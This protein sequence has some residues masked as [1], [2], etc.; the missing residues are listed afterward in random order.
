[1]YRRKPITFKHVMAR[2]A[3]VRTVKVGQVRVDKSELEKKYD[4]SHPGADE[5][6]YVK[7]PNVSGL[8]EAMDMR[9]AQ[10]SYEA[11]LSAIEASRSMMMGTIDLLK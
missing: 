2:E 7:Q 3:G 1:P 11:N 9:E 10:R 6:G 4:P 8:V 5:Q